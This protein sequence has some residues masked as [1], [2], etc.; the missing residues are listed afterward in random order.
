MKYPEDKIARSFVHHAQVAAAIY[1]CDGGDEFVRQHKG[2]SVGVRRVCRPCYGKNNTG[3]E[4]DLTSLA[5]R[6]LADAKGVVVEELEDGVDFDGEGRKLKYGVPDMREHDIEE[7][8][9]F[10]SLHLI[11][12]DP[13]SVDYFNLPEAEPERYDQF[14][15]A[16]YAKCEAGQS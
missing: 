2:L 12:G 10:D 5:P 7:N 6:T 3:E 4:M 8:M 1:D 11:C 15:E 13:G 9:S 16:Y 14:M